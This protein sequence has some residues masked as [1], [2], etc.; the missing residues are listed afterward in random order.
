MTF[1][2]LLTFINL[3]C[4]INIYFLIDLLLLLLALLNLLSISLPANT[5]TYNTLTSFTVSIIRKFIPYMS[6]KDVI[7][8]DK[9]LESY[10][11]DSKDFF[12]IMVKIFFVVNTTVFISLALYLIPSLV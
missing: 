1:L 7:K 2:I 5:P 12:L 9:T 11:V 8:W 3:I 4:L 6:F 10:Y